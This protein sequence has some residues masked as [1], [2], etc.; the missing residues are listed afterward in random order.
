METSEL[1]EA[2][3]RRAT[4]PATRTDM[5][6]ALPVQPPL[7]AE[8]EARSVE[9]LGFRPPELFLVLLREVGNGG[10]GPGYGFLGLEEG[11]VNEADETA[12]DFYCTS[13]TP[14]PDDPAW[15]WPERLVP[16]CSW[17]CAIYTCLDCTDDDMRLVQWDPNV[18]EPGTDPSVGLFEIATPLPRWLEDWVAGVHLWDQIYGAE[19]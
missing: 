19:T 15:A 2:V 16:V 13:R 10:F 14:D 6:A 7:R 3:R 17:G 8:A 5:G 12:V 9:R 18:W 11:E 1:V 4:D